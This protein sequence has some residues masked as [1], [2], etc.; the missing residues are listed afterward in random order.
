MT[1]KKESYTVTVLR[2]A[3]TGVVLEEDWWNAAGLLHRVGGPAATQRDAKTGIVI[4][5]GWFR[6]GRC[7]RLIS[8]VPSPVRKLRRKNDPRAPI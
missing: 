1:L 3:T 7:E 6:N 4:Q 8:N 2:D 5:E